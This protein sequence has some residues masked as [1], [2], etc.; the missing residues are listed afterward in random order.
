MAGKKRFLTV[1]AL[2]GR[3]VEVRVGGG[4]CIRGSLRNV[5]PDF[6]VIERPNGR[7]ALIA[8]AA[9]TVI[10]EEFTASCV[11]QGGS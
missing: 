9:L 1:E 5:G 6:I 8:R 11:N 10:L 2:L 7:A 4:A 3:D